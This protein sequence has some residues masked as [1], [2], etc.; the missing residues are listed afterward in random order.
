MRP[1]ATCTFRASSRLCAAWIL[2]LAVNGMIGMI[3][4]FAIVI[5]VIEQRLSSVSSRHSRK[6]LRIRCRIF[7]CMNPASTCTV[8]KELPHVF[9]SAL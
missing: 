4:T 3:A 1:R 6:G 9:L 8:L 2:V 5:C 7:P